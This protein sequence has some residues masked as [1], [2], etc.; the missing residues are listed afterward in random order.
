[1]A[2]GMTALGRMMSVAI[3]NDNYDWSALPSDA[4]IVDV[5]G[6]HGLAC[7]ALAS[8]HPGFRFV[9][10]DLPSTIALA[11]ANLPAEFK[12][13]IEFQEH[14]F[15]TPQP[16]QG[17]DVYFLR[18]IIH[19]WSDKY[20]IAILKALVPAMKKGAR[21]IVHDMH[22]PEPKE[23][24]WWQDRQARAS[25]LRMKLLFNAHD[26]ERGEWEGLFARVDGRFRVAMPKVHLRDQGN[27]VGQEMVVVEAVWE[28]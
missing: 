23:L 25:N 27:V 17:A 6:G 21:V 20:A 10:Q 18:A 28:G 9:V 11:R 13:R 3:T 14:D 4:L 1:M 2:Y 5:G 15:F 26:R 24:G 22:T 7:Q 8:A 19:D 12:G 16:V